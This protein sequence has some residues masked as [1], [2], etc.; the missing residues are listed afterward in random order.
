MIPAMA[1]KLRVT[2]QVVA[3]MKP[4][5]WE[6]F[7]LGRFPCWIVGEF[8]GFAVLPVGAFGGPIGLKVARHHQGDL[9]DPDNLNRVPTVADEKELVD[10]LKAF[11]PDAYA[12]TH[13]MKVCMYTNTPDENFILDYLPGFDKDVAIAAGFSGHGF[14]FSSVV[15]EI[16]ADLAM[17]GETSLP[18]GFLSAARFK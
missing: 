15:G 18:I 3:W 14:K 13:V 10:A 7:A 4:K 9:S 1:S 12:E 6:P 11:V 5:Q 17:K 2:R 8:Y 16:M